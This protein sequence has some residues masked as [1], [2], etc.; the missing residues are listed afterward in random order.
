MRAFPPATKNHGPWEGLLSKQDEC[1]QALLAPTSHNLSLSDAIFL[2][3]SI[4]EAPRGSQAVL[5]RERDGDE[6]RALTCV[7]I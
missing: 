5:G 6:N 7:E 1:C 2:L 4:R 3:L